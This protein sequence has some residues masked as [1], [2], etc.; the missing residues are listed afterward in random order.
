M[1]WLFA[2]EGGP[3]IKV[4]AYFFGALSELRGFVTN[5]VRIRDALPD[6]GYHLPIGVCGASKTEGR[7]WAKSPKM[8]CSALLDAYQYRQSGRHPS[9]CPIL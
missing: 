8:S 3:P 1:I 7:E 4:T 6:L 5:V 9:I 2:P